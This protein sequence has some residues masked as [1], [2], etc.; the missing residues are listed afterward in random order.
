MK[1]PRSLSKSVPTASAS[2]EIIEKPPPTGPSPQS[3]G[4]RNRSAMTGLAIKGLTSI[5]VEMSYLLTRQR[6]WRLRARTYGSSRRPHIPTSGNLLSTGRD[7]CSS[8]PSPVVR[9]ALKRVLDAQVDPIAFA[10]EQIRRQGRSDEQVGLELEQVLSLDPGLSHRIAAVTYQNRNIAEGK[11]G[12]CSQPLDRN[13][14]RYC[15]R[16]LAAAR[17]RMGPKGEPGSLDYLYDGGFE[18]KHGRQPGT[19]A[20]LAIA[21]EQKTRALLAELGI[22]F[23]SAAVTL[24]AARE[25]LLKCMPHSQTDAMTATELCARAM[26]PTLKTGRKALAELFRAGL[27]QKIGAGASENLFRF[28]RGESR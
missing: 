7:E 19:L 25:A 2:D 15:T 20:S 8:L 22:P 23:E 21:R 10:K 27:V 16:H 5:G 18:S 12:L 24:N 6:P 3:R 13:S 17:A 26:I 11:C 1:A 14:V 9:E 28:F 4:A